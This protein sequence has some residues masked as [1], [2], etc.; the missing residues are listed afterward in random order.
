M[1]RYFLLFLFLTS[2]GLHPIYKTNNK[3]SDQSQSYRKEL[4]SIMVLVERKK[5]NQDLKNNLEKT[6]NPEGIKTDPKYSISIT[7][8]RSLSSTF[9]NFT[10]SSGRNKVILVAN[11]QLKD[12]NSKEVIATGTTAAKDNFDVEDK[13]FANYIAEDAIASNLTL[14]IARNIRDLLINDIVNN[15]KSKDVIKE[16][17]KK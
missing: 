3:I 5:I 13:S 2:C 10:G 15:Y 4:A 11:Y 1:K 12:L 8:S 9:T 16:D 14:I 17:F 6:L 7:L